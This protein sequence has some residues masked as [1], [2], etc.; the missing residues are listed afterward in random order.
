MLIIITI[1]II[2]ITITTVRPEPHQLLCDEEINKKK[3]A[4]DIPAF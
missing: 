2:I 3:Q 4:P 1:I